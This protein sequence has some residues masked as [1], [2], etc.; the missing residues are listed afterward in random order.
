MREAGGGRASARF[1]G[2]GRASKHGRWNELPTHLL[3]LGHTLLGLGERVALGLVG[4]GFIIV[5]SHCGRG[6]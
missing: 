5:G 6:G 3:V 1:A 4:H 2:G